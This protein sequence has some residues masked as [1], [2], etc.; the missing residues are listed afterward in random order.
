[1]KKEETKHIE[2]NNRKARFNYTVVDTYIAGIVLQGNEVKSLRGGNANISESYCVINDSEVFCLNSYIAEYI[3]D[4]SG[5]DPYRQRKLLLNKKEIKKIAKAIE[6]PGYTLVPLKIYFN[7]QN[8]A[9]MLIGVCKGKHDYDK[10][11]T[12]KERD[13]E[14]EMRHA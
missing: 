13:L 10:R 14:R 6:E 5:Y 9:K 8:R 4:W 3:K 11:E 12:I 7:E 2:I 1:M